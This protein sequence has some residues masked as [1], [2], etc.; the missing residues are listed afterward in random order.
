MGDQEKTTTEL[1]LDATR[2]HLAYA[3]KCLREAVIAYR[4][5][6]NKKDKDVDNRD[7]YLARADLLKW[8]A[9]CRDLTEDIETL[10]KQVETNH[11]GEMLFT[12]GEDHA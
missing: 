9:Q 3:E 6:F 2:E 4:N 12:K 8:K 7:V 11:A 5:V 1:L 10:H